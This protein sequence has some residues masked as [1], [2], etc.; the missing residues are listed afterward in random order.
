MKLILKLGTLRPNG[1]NI[2]FNFLWLWFYRAFHLRTLK[3][4]FSKKGHVTRSNFSFNL[5]RSKRCVASC[6]KNFT[7]NTPFCNCNCC[8]E[9]CKNSRTTLYYKLLACNIS[10]ATLNA[11]LSEW[12]NQS[13]SL[14][15]GRFQDASAILFVIVRVASCEKSFKTCDTPSAT[16]KD[17]FI[18]HRCVANCKKHCFV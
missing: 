2:N 1:L 12:A 18:R 14:A 7:C 16:W 6:K 17:F 15:R 4:W 10:S 3:Q 5:Q 11:I 9:S 8:V 13:S